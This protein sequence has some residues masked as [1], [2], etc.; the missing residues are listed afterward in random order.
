MKSR[1]RKLED[2]KNNK[3]F[4]IT[5]EDLVNEII[6]KLISNGGDN[7]KTIEELIQKYNKKEAT[8]RER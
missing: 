8:I 5:S 2:K 6:E 1:K 3:N 4:K 7:E